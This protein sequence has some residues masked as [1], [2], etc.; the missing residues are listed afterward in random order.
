[1]NIFAGL[2]WAVTVIAAGVAA[3]QLFDTVAG[4]APAPQQAAG[5]AVALAIAIIPY[6]F[7]R[8]V[9]SVAASARLGEMLKLLRAIAQVPEREK[10]KPSL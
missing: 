4:A 10:G 5:A 9:D 8:A 7:S 6:V 3:I 1:M 2:C